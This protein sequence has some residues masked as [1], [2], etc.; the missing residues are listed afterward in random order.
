M[1]DAYVAEYTHDPDADLPYEIGFLAWLAGD[2][3]EDAV[4]TVSNPLLLDLHDDEVIEDDSVARVW[5]LGK[6]IEGDCFVTVHV[7]TADGRVDDR[8]LY[9][10]LRN[11]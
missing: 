9:V 6:G 2:T 11:R 4:W 8:T 7:T 5:F 10:K 3:L 1:A